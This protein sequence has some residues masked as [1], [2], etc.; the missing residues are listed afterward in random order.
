[1]ARDGNGLSSRREAEDWML[2]RM[3]RVQLRVQS[4]RGFAIGDG[5]GNLLLQQLRTSSLVIVNVP[6]RVIVYVG[7][8]RMYLF[9]AREYF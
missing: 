1:M 2:C 9:A 3:P 7:I 8:I 5:E 6:V 4:W